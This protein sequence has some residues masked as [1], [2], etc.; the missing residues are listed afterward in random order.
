M[1]VM[2]DLEKEVIELREREKE[3]NLV[4]K[5]GINHVMKSKDEVEKEAEKY[6]TEALV[7]PDTYQHM[8][9]YANIVMLHSLEIV[10]KEK[11]INQHLRSCSLPL[12]LS[13]TRVF[14]QE[15]KTMVKTDGEIYSSED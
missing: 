11:D 13:G 7:P 12:N 6:A 9:D 5:Y 14:R 15:Q 2:R 3:G 8:I 1:W 10:G 4:I